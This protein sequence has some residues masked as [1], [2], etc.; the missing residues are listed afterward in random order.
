MRR[1]FGG[2]ALIV[3]AAGFFSCRKTEPPA[4]NR[5]VA[6]DLPLPKKR[7]E[8][9]GMSEKDRKLLA[10]LN[11]THEQSLFEWRMERNDRHELVRPAPPGFTLEPVS[12]KIKLTL[13]PQATQLRKGERFTYRLELQNVGREALSVWDGSKSLFKTGEPIDEHFRF[14]LSGPDGELVLQSEEKAIASGGYSTEF[15]LPDERQLTS[16]QR[17][18]RVRDLNAY[19][20]RIDQL[21]VTLLPGETL[22]SRAPK[23]VDPV[24]DFYRTLGGK[25]PPKPAIPG[26]HA[27]QTSYQFTRPGTYRLRVVYDDLPP[28]RKS[29]PMGSE[30]DRHTRELDDVLRQYALGRFESQDVVFE[31]VP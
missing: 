16:E 27:L 26:F 7:A 13:I 29:S 22:Y 3:L 20:E 8:R 23:K 15:R 19:S 6:P 28:V 10:A 11:A 31:V 12:R 17:S 14:Y 24:E 4:D 9:P 2:L 1:L 5:P 25:I 21:R 18:L 30:F